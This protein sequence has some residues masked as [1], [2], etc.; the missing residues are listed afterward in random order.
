[1]K[2]NYS[3]PPTLSPTIGSPPT[4]PTYPL[5]PN[6]TKPADS[7]SNISWES[8]LTTSTCSAATISIQY[9]KHSLISYAIGSNVVEYSSV[10]QMQVNFF[11]GRST[12]SAIAISP[13]FKYLFT[14]E[15][16]CKNPSISVWDLNVKEKTNQQ[17]VI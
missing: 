17:P 9:C 16:N 6:S 4:S 14:A 12:I 13:D 15:S 3:D 5:S 10:E 2:T 11:F 1:M 7:N 8:L